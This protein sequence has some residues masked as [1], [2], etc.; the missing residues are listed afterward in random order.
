MPN[1]RNKGELINGMAAAGNCECAAGKQ[2]GKNIIGKCECPPSLAQEH[3]H[4][5]RLQEETIKRKGGNGRKANGNEEEGGG[6][7]KMVAWAGELKGK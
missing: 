1:E 4:Q 6:N 7:I 3:H 2:Q 5:M